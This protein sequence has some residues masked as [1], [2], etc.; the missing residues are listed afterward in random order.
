MSKILKKKLAKLDAEIAEVSAIL[1]PM[2][3]ALKPYQDK[4]IELSKK[5]ALIDEKIKFDSFEPSLEFI[6]SHTCDWFTYKS[7][8]KGS[9]NLMQKYM[10]DNYK[11]LTISGY[12][13]KTNI[14]ALQIGIKTGAALEDVVKEI[15]RPIELAI[16]AGQEQFSIFDDDLSE[17]GSKGLTIKDGKYEVGVMAYHSYRAHETFDNLK[18]VVK[19]MIARKMTYTL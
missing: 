16:K 17:H 13:R 5:R 10:R 1:K 9:Y 7:N 4:H 15:E 19:Y 12:N 6:L 2:Y 14:Y 8:G 11:H 3:D 18:D